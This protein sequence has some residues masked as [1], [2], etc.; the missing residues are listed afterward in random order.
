MSRH[1][2]TTLRPFAWKTQVVV[3]S[4]LDAN[5]PHTSQH[6]VTMPL[7]SPL[8][9]SLGAPQLRAEDPI[10]VANTRKSQRL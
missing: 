9:P 4:N 3:G 8:Q 2:A 6:E 1:D 10:H 5:H 7:G